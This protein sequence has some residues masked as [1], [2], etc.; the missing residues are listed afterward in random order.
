WATSRGWHRE[1]A[2]KKR[3][4]PVTSREGAPLV[5]ERRHVRFAKSEIGGQVHGK[6]RQ[7]RSAGKQFWP[8]LR[9]SSRE[10]PGKIGIRG[11]VRRMR[12]HASCSRTA[13]RRMH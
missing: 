8:F 11:C 13:H 5:P 6:D 2:K 3:R 9:S 7:P 12:M 1:A 4:F 10:K